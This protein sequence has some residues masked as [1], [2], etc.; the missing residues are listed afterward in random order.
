MGKR[1]SLEEFMPSDAVI[2]KVFD[3]KRAEAELAPLRANHEL[4]E[5]IRALRELEHIPPMVAEKGEAVHTRYTP[6]PMPAGTVPEEGAPKVVVSSPKA[7][8]AQME[9]VDLDKMRVPDGARPVPADDAQRDKP[10]DPRLGETNLVRRKKKYTEEEQARARAEADA[11]FATHAPGS[12]EFT[13][14]VQ[15]CHAFDLKLPA[16]DLDD[17]QAFADQALLDALKAPVGGA[18]ALRAADEPEDVAPPP[19]RFTSKQIAVGLVALVFLL[20]VVIYLGVRLGRP[21]GPEPPLTVAPPN[22][23]TTAIELVTNTVAPMPT[24]APGPTG[25][26]AETATPS[27]SVTATASIKVSP[28]DA[29]ARLSASSVETP[30]VPPTRSSATTFFGNPATSPDAGPFFKDPIP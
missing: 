18:A 23:P 20:P 15:L 10:T 29:T 4:R 30:P 17:V 28:P 7:D 27:P 9:R 2:E 24:A 22:L 3:R 16:V 12:A 26:A 14:G 21:E 19:R 8:T 6:K 1:D 11:I 13:R 5:E 25:D